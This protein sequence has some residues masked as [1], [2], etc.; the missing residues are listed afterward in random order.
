MLESLN[1]PLLWIGLALIVIGI[2]VVSV[3][4]GKKRSKELDELDRMFPEQELLE[5]TGISVEKV[6][7]T[8]REREKRRLEAQ[9]LPDNTDEDV[10]LTEQKD[11]DYRSSSLIEHKLEKAPSQLDDEQRFNSSGAEGRW[12][13]R[14]N[15]PGES[16]SK[17]VDKSEEPNPSPSKFASKRFERSEL[18][19]KEVETVEGIKVMDSTSN[20]RFYKAEPIEAEIK[21]EQDITSASN[22]FEEESATRRPIR[23]ATSMMGSNPSDDSE[24]PRPT[25]K[26]KRLY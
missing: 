1:G 22:T 21:V 12:Q 18:R 17:E 16:V 7:R 19:K 3:I 8:T 4:V 13:Q 23:R 25:F 11:Y 5:D 24:N 14:R 20:R 15:K 10:E 26:K 6:R 9:H 2:I